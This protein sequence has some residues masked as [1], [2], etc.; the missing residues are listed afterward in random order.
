MEYSDTKTFERNRKL[1]FE[2]LWKNELSMMHPLD[3]MP[4]HLRD[5]LKEFS[6]KVYFEG[7]RYETANIE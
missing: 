3:N 1:D 2:H 7:S 5:K 4:S 6:W